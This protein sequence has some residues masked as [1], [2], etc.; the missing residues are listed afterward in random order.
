MKL[1]IVAATALLTLTSA[2]QACINSVGTDAAGRKFH[3]SWPV[4]QDFVR[5]LKGATPPLFWVRTTVR[6]AL[7][8]PSF[9][10]LND[11]GVLLIRQGQFAAAVR[12]FVQVE[13][14]YPGH[15]ETA[16]NLGTALELTGHDATALRWIRIG[17]RRNPE[18]HHRSEWLHLRIL[19]AKLALAK[20][21]NHLQG[22]S[23]AGIA[24][25][26]TLVPPLPT[27]LPAGNDGR[28]VSPWLLN[29]SFSYQLHE[30]LQ[31]VA[32]PDPV[33][34]NLLRDWATL[35][36]AGG[37]IETADAVYDL[38]VRYGSERDAL[39]T[40]RQQH[41]RTVLARSKGQ[42][43]EHDHCAICAPPSPPAPQ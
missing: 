7:I 2:A 20:D 1:R 42:E 38:A 22:R 39:M 30:R 10:H 27:E 8:D 18:E 17:I 34:A 40:K 26:P 31:F 9:E 14:L 23:V 6:D 16:A 37:P 11:L 21:P 32:A 15:H 3:P 43:A 25:A 35:N 33:V 41:I 13:K 4:G 24:F 12:H 36:L 5:E 19:E 28:P 29:W